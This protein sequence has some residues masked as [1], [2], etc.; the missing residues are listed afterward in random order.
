MNCEEKWKEEGKET[1]LDETNIGST[2]IDHGKK[3]RGLGDIDA[4]AEVR[5]F[6]NDSCEELL[7]CCVGEVRSALFV[8]LLVRAH[9]GRMREA[10]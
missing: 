1:C 6:A 4:D 5:L 9:H 10:Q 7:C 2:N 8:S 3:V